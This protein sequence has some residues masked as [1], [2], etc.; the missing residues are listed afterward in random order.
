MISNNMQDE[1]VNAKETN[2]AKDAVLSE[3]NIPEV[4]FFLL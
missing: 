4:C 2:Q 3:K 1:L